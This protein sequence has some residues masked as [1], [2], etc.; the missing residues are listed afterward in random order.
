M[1]L[2]EQKIPAKYIRL[3]KVV[4]EIAADKVRNKQNPVLKAR[5]YR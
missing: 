2:L 1:A 3:E 5:E 4:A